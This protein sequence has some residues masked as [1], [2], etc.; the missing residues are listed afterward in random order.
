MRVRRGEQVRGCCVCSARGE[1]WT[2]RRGVESAA[3]AGGHGQCHLFLREELYE[4]PSLRPG[5]G[6]NLLQVAFRRRPASV[7]A[8]MCH[9]PVRV[10]PLPPLRRWLLAALLGKQG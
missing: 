6:K 8:Q 7:S 2:K 1:G 9:R 10:S 3:V 5:V 4:R